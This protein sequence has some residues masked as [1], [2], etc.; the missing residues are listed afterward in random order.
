MLE[1]KDRCRYPDI[2]EQMEWDS[3]IQVVAPTNFVMD[4]V[5]T[6]DFFNHNLLKGVTP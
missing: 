3:G 1:L 5:G 6:K 4:L 2:N